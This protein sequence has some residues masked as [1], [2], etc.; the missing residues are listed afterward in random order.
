MR[1]Y[2]T[3]SKLVTT[4]FEGEGIRVENRLTWDGTKASGLKVGSG[5]YYYK[6]VTEKFTQ[7]RKMVLLK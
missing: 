3:Q 6:L 5:V 1:L 2:D 4:L 7:T